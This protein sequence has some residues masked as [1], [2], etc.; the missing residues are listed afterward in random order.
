M[1]D[2]KPADG[3]WEGSRLG[4]VPLGLLVVLRIAIGWHFLYEGIVKLVDPRWTSAPFLAESRWLLSGVFQAIVENPLALRTVDFLNIWGLILIGLGLILGCLTRFAVV[5]GILL[6]GLYY[7][8][9][10]PL[11]ATSSGFTEGNYLVVDKNLVELLALLVLAFVPTGHYVGLDR[12]I[13]LIR[14][15]RSEESTLSQKVGSTDQDTTTPAPP[16]SQQPISLARRE[17]IRNLAGVP[18][19]GGLAYA[20]VRKQGWESWE[21]RH[22]LAAQ[23]LDAVSSATMKTFQYAS[24]K[25]LKG[26]LPLGQIGDLELSRMFLGGNLMGGWA[27][28]RD[29]IY[30]SKLVKT[31]HTDEKIFDTFRIAER[32]GLNTILTNPILCRVISKYWRQ[33][34]GKI[35]FISDCAYK[36]DLMT[37]IKMSVDTGAHS[38]Y[39]QGGVADRLVEQGKVDEI[40]KAVDFIRQNGVPA[41]IGA[42]KLE[43]VQ[44]CV[45]DGL[46]PDYWVKTLHHCQYWSARPDEAEHDNIWCT[47]PDETIAYMA[48]RE[49]PWIAFK[50]LAAGAIP[51][52][53]GFRYALENGADF[54]CVGMYDFQIVED[55][56]IAYDL[57]KEGIERS[58]PWQA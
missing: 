51:P 36:N 40:G 49:E 44:A 11:I 8:A 48:E 58:R 18:A 3:S 6:L 30:V 2:T 23:D 29:L 10:P 57:L 22:L 16:A 35:Q 34:G 5:S 56:N 50:V 26:Q 47:H 27:H 32:C 42:H 52:D 13:A 15:S 24:L 1:V 19:L 25:D 41:G 20:V 17:W 55:T 9:N 54:I 38:C 28:A 39:V 45:D 53:V 12:L 33:K 7:V 4:S 21:E 14:R 37:G 31:Y 46:R 43:T